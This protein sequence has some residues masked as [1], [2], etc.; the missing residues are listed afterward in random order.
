MYAIIEA[1]GRQHKVSNGDVLRLNLDVAEVEKTVTFDRVLLVGGEGAAKIGAPVVAGATVV[2]DV[3]RA[4]KG[5]K[6]DIVKYKRRKGH[7]KKIGHRQPLVEVKI[8]AINV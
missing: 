2:A 7:H 3:I 8:T 6:I 5:P 1:D 4:M